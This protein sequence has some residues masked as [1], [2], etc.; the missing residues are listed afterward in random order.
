MTK[1]A[2]LAVLPIFLSGSAAFA[3]DMEA[4][5]SNFLFRWHFK[6][7]E[8]KAAKAGKKERGFLSIGLSQN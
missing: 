1:T 8:K 3:E 5:K 4:L 2:I 6:K 7:Q